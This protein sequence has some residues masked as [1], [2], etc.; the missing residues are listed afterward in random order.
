MTSFANIIGHASQLQALQT[1][2]DQNNVSHAYLLAGPNHIGKRAIAKQFAKNLICVGST[3]AESCAAQCDKL[4]H[5]DLLILD[6]LYQYGE[7]TDWEYISKFS[8][9]SQDHR[10]KS[11]AKTDSISIDDIRA[12]QE[13]IH[14]RPLGA[15]RV[16]IITNIERMSAAPANALL[17]LLEEPPS[18]VVFVLTCSAASSLLPTVVSR[19][20]LLNFTRVSNE[21]LHTALQVQDPLDEQFIVHLAQ[22]APGLALTL[23]DNPEQL[24]LEKTLHGQAKQFWQARNNKD[25][26]Q[27]LEPLKKRSPE[28]VALWLHLCLTAK[29]LPYNSSRYEALLS[30]SAALETNVHRVTLINNFVMNLA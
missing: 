17:K 25:R 11:Q 5:P 3:N 13:V 20:R 21:V 4:L 23:R 30:M 27:V 8:N 16:C 10:K 2:I 29:E 24:R 15:H 6:V 9:V 26:L 1:D 22:G 18:Q 14:D 7:V 28:A 12:I 19:T